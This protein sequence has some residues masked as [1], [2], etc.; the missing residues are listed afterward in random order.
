[1]RMRR[2]LVLGALLLLPGAAWAQGGAARSAGITDRVVAVVGSRAILAT[3]V[4]EALFQ[5]FPGG[6]GLPTDSLQLRAL[7]REV[8]ESLID[9]ELLVMEAERDT[10]IKVTAEDVQEA[11]EQTF[12]ATRGR[13]PSEAA[14]RAEIRTA[15]FATPEEY[16]GWLSEDQRRALL[17]QALEQ[18][19][20]QAGLIK[21]VT[22]TEAEMRALFEREKANL[23]PRPPQ[24]SFGQVLIAP[25]PTP[26]AL[27][28]TMALADS[29]VRE[30]RAG[31]DFPSAA[32]RF[33]A[34]PGSREQGGSLDWFR[35]GEMVPEFERVAFSFRPG[36]IS[37]PVRSPFGI[38]IIQVE[39]IQPAE[40]KA[41]HILLQ[42]TVGPE[43][44]DS[45]R[46]L[47]LRVHAAL[48]AGAS[49]D[50]IQRL[51]H[52]GTVP[53][54]TSLLPQTN[55][56]QVY[57]TAIGNVEPGQLAPLI[58]LPEADSTRTK[59]A[60]VRVTARTP[61]GEPRYEDVVEEIRRTLS[62]RIG[63]RRYIDKLRQATYVEVRDP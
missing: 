8:L 18:V 40:V 30:L 58:T 61:G 1:M 9:D 51:H 13:Y 38:H 3:Q 45:A 41:R 7:Q 37:D 27:A 11:V 42:P 47:A 12:R 5:R 4:D 56:P 2:L 17:M 55:L 22:P 24:I 39:R 21:P 14:F 44:G 60:V 25:Q 6:E 62:R 16:R 20:S 54:T 15:G 10:T 50:S 46:V 49:L 63:I 57:L 35:R 43:Q 31:A 52:D 36:Y 32:R 28:I 33:S 48:Q 19:R 23:Q 26:E 53:E 34:D 59:Y 29:I